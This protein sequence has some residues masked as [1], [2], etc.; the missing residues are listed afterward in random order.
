M[1]WPS[2]FLRPSEWKD[3]IFMEGERETI[4]G[5]IVVGNRPLEK[6]SLGTAAHTRLPRNISSRRS[7]GRLCT[8]PIEEETRKRQRDPNNSL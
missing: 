7:E 4:E 2:G 1:R 6:A 5:R 3:A 8:H